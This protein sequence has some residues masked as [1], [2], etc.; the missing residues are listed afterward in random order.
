[1]FLIPNSCEN[2]GKVLKDSVF[3][4]I[5]KTNLWKRCQHKEKKVNT[6]KEKKGKQQ[7]KNLCNDIN[8]CH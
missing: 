4:S 5:C 7:T 6:G 1:M 3:H 8:L 2:I